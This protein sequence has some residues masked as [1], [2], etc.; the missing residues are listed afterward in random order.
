[1]T[2][3]DHYREAE[4]LLQGRTDYYNGG[5]TVVDRPPTPENVALAQV[6]A[7]LALVAA[8]AET[9]HTTPQQE[10]GG[11]SCYLDGDPGWSAATGD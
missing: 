6:H 4:R 1:M 2:G 11:T 8:T 5:Q 10:W 7:T 3:P 9:R